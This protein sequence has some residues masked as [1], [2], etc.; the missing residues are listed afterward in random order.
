MCKA[1]LS[2]TRCLV[3]MQV[4]VLLLLTG[5]LVACGPSSPATSS[6]TPTSKPAIPSV[7]IT[8]KD[9]SF[10]IPAS[11]PAGLVD[12]TMVNQGADD[13]QAQLARL[14]DG[15]TP[16]QFLTALKKDPGAALPLVKLAGGPNVASPGQSQEVILNLPQGQYV[17]LC[18]VAGKDNIPHIQKGMIKFFQVTGPSNAGQVSE[19]TATTQVTLKD[20][21]F[22]LPSTIAAGPQLLQVTNQGPQ[23]H[24]MTLFKLAPGK[25]VQDVVAF[26]KKPA[27]PPPMTDAGGIA[28]LAPRTSGWLKVNLTPGNYVTICFIPDPATGKAHFELGM[29]GS[30]S[31]Q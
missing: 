14:N 22:V 18:F 27:G 31:V 3:T 2:T 23:P 12:V 7:T 30:F 21:A 1:T 28:G 29:I 13:H 11:I 17:A 20:F 19:P 24:E 25:Q 10:V 16:D 9:F 15:V 26:L 8:A 4:F 6:P 5:L